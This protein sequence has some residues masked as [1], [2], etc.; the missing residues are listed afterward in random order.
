MSNVN[1]ELHKYLREIFREI[2]DFLLQEDPVEEKDDVTTYSDPVL[3]AIA[4]E[5]QQFRA[6]VRVFC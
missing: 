5:H 1:R 6:E 4:M 2:D 3:I